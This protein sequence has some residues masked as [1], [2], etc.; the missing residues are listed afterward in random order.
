MK[1]ATTEAE[2]K[3][4][5]AKVDALNGQLARSPRLGVMRRTKSSPRKPRMT[6]ALKRSAMQRR[7]WKLRTITWPA[8]GL[9]LTCKPSN[10]GKIK[11]KTN[12][13]A[14]L[15]L[16]A[17]GCALLSGCGSSKQRTRLSRM[18]ATYA[19]LRTPTR[20]LQ[21]WTIRWLPACTP[22]RPSRRP[23]SRR[24]RQ[25]CRRSSPGP[26]WTI[27]ADLPIADHRASRDPP[28]HRIRD[29]GRRTDR[30][31]CFARTTGLSLLAPIAKAVL[32]VTAI[33]TMDQ[34]FPMLDT[35]FLQVADYV[36]PGYTQNPTAAAESVRASTAINPSSQPWSWRHLNQSIYQAVTDA[37]ANVFVYLGTL[38]TIPLLILNMCSGGCCTFLHRLR[39]RSFSFPDLAASAC[40]F[41]SRSWPSTHG[42][43]AS[44]LPI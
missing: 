37:I 43:W 36:D 11:M 35:T 20:R 21:M 15:L 13:S 17:I 38:I 40:A 18:T 25:R 16:A 27:L 6:P 12:S 7:N 39:W 41:S 3:K 42:P 23:H 44:R 34:W 32:I 26:Q 33:A 14:L 31:R 5:S 4:Q 19:L 1:N 9:P 2:A 28:I 8:N 30:L 22:K 10:S 29:H 24:P